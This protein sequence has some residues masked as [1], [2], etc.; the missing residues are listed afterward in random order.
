MTT[1]D[2]SLLLI[3]LSSCLKTVKPYNL[4][5][6]TLFG[7]LFLSTLEVYLYLE[8]MDYSS[9]SA[10]CQFMMGIH[11]ARMEKMKNLKGGRGSDLKTVQC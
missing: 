11:F 4:W 7:Y 5:V 8:S 6:Y 10:D 9:S 2:C 1:D 3:I